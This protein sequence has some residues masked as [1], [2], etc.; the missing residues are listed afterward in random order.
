MRRGGGG[1]GGA[2]RFLS[3]QANK[4]LCLDI[5]FVCDVGDLPG[6]WIETNSN[7]GAEPLSKYRLYITKKTST[8]L[9]AN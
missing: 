8:E 9:K 5:T 3:H 7:K 6:R 4:I 2:G 1:R